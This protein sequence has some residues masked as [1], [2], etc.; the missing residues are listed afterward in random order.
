MLYPLK[1][2]PRL[3][4]IIWGGKDFLP[5]IKAGKGVRIAS[6]KLYGESW[7]ISSVAGDISVV[8]NGYLKRNNLEEII[9]VYM[10]NLMGDKV[11]DR[12]G[13]MFPLLVKT[14]DCNNVLSVQVHPNDELAMERHESY[15]KT[16][17]WYVIDAEPGA[18]LYVGFKD[19]NTTREKYIEA[20][21]NDTLPELLNKVEVK[22]GDVFFIPAGT[23][24]ALGKGIK[25][26][27]IQQTSD[28]TYRIY[29]WNRVDEHGKS[30]E[31]H[32]A[33]AIDAIDFAK[34]SEDCQVK[35]QYAKNEAVKL[36]DCPYF[37]INAI[38]VDGEVERDVISRDS[39]VMYNCVE[40]EVDIV[41]NDNV[42]HLSLSDVVLI[43]A[44][45]DSV[46]IKGRGKLMETYISK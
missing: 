6:D 17:M 30:R 1:F 44:E 22:A 36:I 26:V 25:V 32:T 28:I 33:L 5:A 14:L 2:I 37:T 16:E 15:G 27:E 20:I 24:H 43:P 11:Y 21:N 13:L 23:I 39:F 41:M 40:G 3:K 38:E 12:Y 9:E 46:V 31:L 35:Y 4:E 34:S 10:G 29:D 7:D 18:S 8:A 42:E 19:K 45:A